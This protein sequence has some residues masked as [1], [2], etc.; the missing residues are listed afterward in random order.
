[1]IY[2]GD[3]QIDRVEV[4]IGELG[5]G[6]HALEQ[7]ALLHHLAVAPEGKALAARVGLRQF[8]FLVP[9]AIFDQVIDV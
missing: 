8:V 5:V 6:Q 9:A 1:M 3:A 7:R 4:L 2:G